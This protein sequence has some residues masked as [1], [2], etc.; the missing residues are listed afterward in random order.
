V[1]QCFV[2]NGK[3]DL[4]KTNTTPTC[5]NGQAIGGAVFNNNFGTLIND[6]AVGTYAE[7]FEGGVDSNTFGNMW[8]RALSGAAITGY[9]ASGGVLTLTS[10]DNNLTAGQTATFVAGGGDN[11]AALNGLSFTVLASPTPSV[12]TFA[13]TTGLVTG[14]GSST[15]IA[16]TGTG[17]IAFA[18]F[19]PTSFGDIQANSFGTVQV[20]GHNTGGNWVTDNYATGIMPTYYPAGDGLTAANAWVENGYGQWTK[21]WFNNIENGSNLPSVSTF[22]FDWRRVAGGA[23]TDFSSYL[24]TGGSGS[25]DDILFKWIDKG[26]GTN[27]HALRLYSNMTGGWEYY[28]NDNTHYLTVK[29]VSYTPTSN[30]TLN[31]PV[32]LPGGASSDT[33]ATVLQFPSPPSIGTTVPNQVNA[34][35]VQVVPAGTAALPITAMFELQPI[36]GTNVLSSATGRIFKLDNGTLTNG[37]DSGTIAMNAINSIGQET[38]TPTS[39]TTYTN[40]ASLYLTGPPIAST[41]ATIN[42]PWTVY[43]AAGKS[44]F[45]LPA[46]L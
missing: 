6:N 31:Y 40:A 33:F 9:S 5:G 17:G 3:D 16:G 39:A 20:D 22:N 29:P 1:G 13:I 43:V 28:F 23:T 4:G 38:L 46:Q 8:V 15:S 32:S 10:T 21:T 12:T 11:L 27:T 7:E 26:S 45:N 2:F 19:C 35:V 14:S 42:N 37:T 24:E 36:T 34:D 30:V 44:Y 25:V 18:T 41:N